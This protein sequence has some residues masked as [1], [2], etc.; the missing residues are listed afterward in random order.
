MCFFSRYTPL[1]DQIALSN[2]L[3][4]LRYMDN[5]CIVLFVSQYVTSQVS[6]LA[7]ISYQV[8][9]LHD[10]KSQN[11]KLNIFYDEKHFSS[12]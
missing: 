2:C 3:Y 5:M 12:F 1:T 6:K 11:K 8:V 9:F 10:Q 4:F 7:R